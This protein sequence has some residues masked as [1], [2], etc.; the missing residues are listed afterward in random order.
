MYVKMKF[1]GFGAFVYVTGDKNE[2]KDFRVNLSGTE[3]AQRVDNSNT[4]PQC[5]ECLSPLEGNVLR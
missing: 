2:K 3:S 4:V 5:T 1:R